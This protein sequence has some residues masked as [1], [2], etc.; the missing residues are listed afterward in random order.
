[1]DD[2]RRCRATSKRAGERCKRAAIPGGRVCTIHGGA[3]PRARAAAE[4]RQAESAAT[5]LLNAIWD[6]D[7]KPITDPVAALQALAG[8]LEHAA[9]V[10]GARLDVEDVDLDNANGTAWVR[11]L[12]ELRQVLVEMERLGLSR[13]EVELAEE[14]AEQLA[15]VLRRIFDRLGLSAEQQQLVPTVVPEELRRLAASPMVV[16]GELK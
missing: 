12:R 6:P 7:A 13:R 2:S 5:A 3:S 14:A 9:R 16:R 10:L 15:A 1:V 4:R 8:R 11:V